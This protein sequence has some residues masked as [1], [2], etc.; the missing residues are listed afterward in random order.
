MIN[1]V[2]EHYCDVCGDRLGLKRS[3]KWDVV[4]VTNPSGKEYEL[5]DDCN[6]KIKAFLRGDGRFK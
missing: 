5:C 4:M 6:R 3:G 2:D 1:V